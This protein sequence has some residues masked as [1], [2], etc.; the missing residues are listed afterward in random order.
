[1]L[2]WLRTVTAGWMTVWV[3]NAV[4]PQDLLHAFSGHHDPVNCGGQNAVLSNL[5]QHCAALALQGYPQHSV[6][7]FRVFRC[8]QQVAELVDRVKPL[9]PAHAEIAAASRSPPPVS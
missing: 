2:R 4:I 5:H 6:Q 1:M 9:V 3:L 7:A 8:W